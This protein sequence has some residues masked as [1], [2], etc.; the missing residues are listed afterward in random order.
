MQLRAAAAA[1]DDAAAAE[2]Q[3]LSKIS[4]AVALALRLCDVN[5][6]HHSR[7]HH[8]NRHPTSG[9]LLLQ[10]LSNSY[11]LSFLFAMYSRHQQ[12]QGQQQQQK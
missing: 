2:A 6:Q 8:H 10:S 9:L 7:K 1:D 4:P 3:G 5:H 12:Q 11:R